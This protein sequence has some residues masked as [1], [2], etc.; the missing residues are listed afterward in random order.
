MIRIDPESICDIQERILGILENKD[1]FSY[2]T[3]DDSLFDSSAYK[4]R[5]YVCFDSKKRSDDEQELK[6]ALMAKMKELEGK[7]FEDP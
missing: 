4:V 2:V 1:G 6:K 7:R 5:A 3:D